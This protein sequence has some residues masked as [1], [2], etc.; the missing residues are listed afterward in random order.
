MAMGL[1]I[2]FAGTVT[3]K[4][5]KRL[6]EIAAG[7]PDEYLLIE[8]DAP[9]L[10]PAPLRGKRNEP[11]FLLHTARKLAELRDVGVG[12]IARITTL[13][14]GRLFG[15]GGISPVGK[16]AYNIRDSLYLN[17]IGRSVV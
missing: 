16:I 17:K 15:I 2:S 7:I 9:Y 8:T 3:F 10:S 6:Q 12:D 5:A 13:N 14:A 4:N 1:Y 11:S